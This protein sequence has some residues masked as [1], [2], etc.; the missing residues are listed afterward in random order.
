MRPSRRRTDVRSVKSLDLDSEPYNSSSNNH[1]AKPRKSL[2]YTSEPVANSTSSHATR[3]RPTPPKKP[4]RLSL[5]RA[6]SLQSVENGLS[7]PSTPVSTTPSS[8][9]PPSG[10]KRTHRGERSAVSGLRW[11]QQG[12]SS[13]A[14]HLHQRQTT[15]W[16]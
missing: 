4:I 11:P 2:D 15:R 13:V 9:V 14:V 10:R 16:C 7:T 3:K 8:E 12:L 1:Y 6:Q 5:H